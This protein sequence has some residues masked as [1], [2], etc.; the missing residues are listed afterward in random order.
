VALRQL[1]EQPCNTQS[2]PHIQRRK[3]TMR[4]LIHYTN[5]GS[6]LLPSFSLADCSSAVRFEGDFG[7]WFETAL[8]DLAAPVRGHHFPVDVYE[9]EDNTY[10][11][12]ELPGVNR[13]DIKVEM[14]EGFLTINASRKS[15]S[16]GGQGEESFSFSRSVSMPENVAADK[17]GA[18]YENGVLTIT[19]PKQEETK[20][21]KITVAVK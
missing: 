7:R 1:N 21:R 20:P 18:A 17:V 8:A 10:V 16:A 9:D 3:T 12:A 5:L 6:R 4:S 14:V 13:E 19:L 2:P 11:R 15:L